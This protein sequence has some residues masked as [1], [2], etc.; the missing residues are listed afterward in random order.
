MC[1]WCTGSLLLVSRTDILSMSPYSSVVAYTCACILWAFGLPHGLL[2]SWVLSSSSEPSLTLSTDSPLNTWAT[3]CLRDVL[4][5]GNV[6]LLLVGSA[7]SWI[8]AV[9]CQLEGC[10]VLSNRVGQHGNRAQTELAHRYG[11]GKC[12]KMQG[13]HAQWTHAGMA[14]ACNEH[15][16]ARNGLCQR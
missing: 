4:R 11:Q 3:H 12:R 14:H 7:L 10:H 9:L 16:R 5:M 2:V 15:V 8:H 13:M 6:R 1:T